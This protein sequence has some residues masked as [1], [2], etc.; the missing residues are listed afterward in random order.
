[1]SELQNAKKAEDMAKLITS[2]ADSVLTEAKDQN[3]KT[4]A[5]CEKAGFDDPE[6]FNLLICFE[7]E[8]PITAILMDKFKDCPNKA[9]IASLYQDYDFYKAH[10]ADYISSVAG[11]AVSVD[12]TRYILRGYLQWLKT[13]ELPDMTRSKEKYSVPPFGTAEEWMAFCS[14]L[15]RL[16]YRFPNEADKKAFDAIDKAA[17]EY[18]DEETRK[19]NEYIQKRNS[20]TLD[21][22]KIIDNGAAILIRNTDE[23]RLICDLLDEYID[24]QVKP[25]ACLMK[26]YIESGQNGNII[27]FVDGNMEVI[28]IQEGKDTPEYILPEF[29]LRKKEDHCE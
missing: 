2:L 23:G 27:R 20:H 28:P 26:Y 5:A 29:I 18:V 4:V 10:I 3:P 21:F 15:Y 22:K 11:S 6:K 8:K 1:M 13:G 9:K 14:S 12:R 19:E 17:K 24:N 16:I 25:H 7:Q